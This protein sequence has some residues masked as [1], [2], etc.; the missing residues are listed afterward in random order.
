MSQQRN[1]GFTELVQD[2][3]EP[4]QLIAY[5]MYKTDKRMNAA[6]HNAVRDCFPRRDI[7]VELTGFATFRKASR[8]IVTRQNGL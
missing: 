5:A 8:T 4:E 3:D 6:I 7:V 1:G 2:S